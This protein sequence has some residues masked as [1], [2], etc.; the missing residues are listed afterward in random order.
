MTLIAS[1]NNLRQQSLMGLQALSQEDAER[2]ALYEQM[3]QAD[4][5]QEAQT[6][7]TVAGIGGAYL[8]NK[9]LPAAGTKV[10]AAS[11]SASG[12]GSASQS[13]ALIGQTAFQASQ[14]KA[15]VGGAELMKLS[16]AASAGGTTGAVGGVT[17]TAAAA[18][19]VAAA[20]PVVAPAT[21]GGGAASLAALT[22]PLAIGIGGA[23]L[24]SQ[25]FG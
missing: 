12:V 23:F 6:Q 22:G 8:L 4:S 7:G 25:L 5:A 15:A 1:G 14:A 2:E 17:G 19:V 3:K 18:P 13:S 24:L 21:T 10:A 11:G 9:G 20:A 16:S